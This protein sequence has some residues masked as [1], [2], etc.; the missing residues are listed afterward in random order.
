MHTISIQEENKEL[1]LL[2]SK[3]TKDCSIKKNMRP[4]HLLH[5]TMN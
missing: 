1:I 2:S 3:P 5:Y 4:V